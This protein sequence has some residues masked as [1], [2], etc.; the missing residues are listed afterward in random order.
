LDIYEPSVGEL[1]HVFSVNRPWLDVCS[2][3]WGDPDSFEVW[4]HQVETSRAACI[5]W[6]LYQGILYL[7]FA[8]HSG[9]IA[10]FL[11]SEKSNVFSMDFVAKVPSHVHLPNLVQVFAYDNMM[12]CVV[13]DCDGELVVLKIDPK[14]WEAST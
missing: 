8:T 5:S 10:I 12:N 3:E 14:N 2:K 1:R 4:L 7:V 9:D 13:A 11:K 6:F